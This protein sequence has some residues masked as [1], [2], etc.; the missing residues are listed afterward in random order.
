MENV[1]MYLKSLGM[2]R[3]GTFLVAHTYRGKTSRYWYN[4]ENATDFV[5]F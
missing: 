5:E 3:I 2:Y 4:Q 1:N